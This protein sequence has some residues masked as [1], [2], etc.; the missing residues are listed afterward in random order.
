MQPRQAQRG[1]LSYRDQ[2][3]LFDV[4]DPEF[5]VLSGRETEAGLSHSE[6]AA[7]RG[8][9][10]LHLAVASVSACHVVPQTALWLL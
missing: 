8:K 1:G 4:A 5:S 10:G 7:R 2:T 9:V 6:A 3:N